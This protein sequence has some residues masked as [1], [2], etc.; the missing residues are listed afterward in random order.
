MRT[1][2][3]K[4]PTPLDPIASL[5]ARYQSNG[6]QTAPTSQQQQKK[7]RTGFAEKTLWDWLQVILIPVV[8]GIYTLVTTTNMATQQTAV[9]EQQTL[10]MQQ[11]NHL[12]EEQLK[13]EILWKYTNTIQDLIIHESLLQSKPDDN[14]R[15]IAKTQTVLALKQL[16]KE[17][18]K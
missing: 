8:L 7:G 11:Q 17:R 18:S 14:V 9:A 1:F 16:N 12:A 4:T 13:S 2:M 10:I 6:H 15:I 5:V 3:A